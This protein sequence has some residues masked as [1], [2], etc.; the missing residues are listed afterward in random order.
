MIRQIMFLFLL[1]L[2][3]GSANAQKSSKKFDPVFSSKEDGAIHGYDPVAYFT[4]GKPVKGKSDITFAWNGA[5]W[6]FAT[7][8][9]RDLFEKNPEKYAPA[10]GGWCA[11]GWSRG[12]PAKTEPDAWS[13]VDGKL[14]LNYNRAVKADWDKKQADYIKS[15]DENW[16]EALKKQ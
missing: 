3:A 7:A 16:A 15:A 13:I 4:N 6:H 5:T 1:F 2:A 12:Y 9:H 11:Y 14:Y 10:Y 8:E